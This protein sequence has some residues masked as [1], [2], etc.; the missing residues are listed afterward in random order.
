MNRSDSDSAL[1]LSHGESRGPYS[2][3]PLLLPPRP[4]PPQGPAPGVGGGLEKSSSLGEL[5]G[6]A[7][8]LASSGSTR[9]LFIT[10][11]AA[12]S[13]AVF[14]SSASS[15]S[16]GS[17]RGTGPQLPASRSPVEEDGGEE[18]ESSGGRRR[19]A[20]NKI[21][22]KKQGR[23]WTCFILIYKLNFQTCFY[24][25]LAGDEILIL[26]VMMKPNCRS[27]GT[28]VFNASLIHFLFN[29]SGK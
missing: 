23:H 22:K 18:S 4:R 7:A 12:D 19:N 6:P 27:E 5:R 2:S 9:S 21:F 28:S 25:L 3:K 14:S 15:S 29:L 10:S 17:A 16:S 8:V 20:F 11:D 13:S 24:Q 26:I 1:P